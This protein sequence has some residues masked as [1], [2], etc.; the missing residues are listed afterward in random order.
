MFVSR[1]LGPFAVGTVIALTMAAAASAQILTGTVVGTVKDAQ[2]GVIPGATV[3]S[4][5]KPAAPKRRQS[6]RARRATSSSEHH[7]RHVHSRG[8]D[9]RR[10]RRRR[11]D[12]RQRRR[13]VWPARLVIEVGG[14]TETVKVKGESPEDSGDDRRAVVHGTYQQVQNLPLSGRSFDVLARSRRAWSAA[15]AAR[16][17]RRQQHHDGR[18]RPRWTPATTPA[19]ADEHRS[20]RRSEGP[21]RPTTRRNT[22][23]R[24]A[25]RSPP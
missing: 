20:D 17:R 18:R 9:A 5:V 3:T 23:A 4:S 24:A 12:I 1:R 7:R 15:R 13:P 8:V 16:R 6:S 11:A 21:D 22:A 19:A 10:S 2:G 25:C 14:P